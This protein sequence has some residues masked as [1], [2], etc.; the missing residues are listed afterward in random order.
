MNIFEFLNLFQIYLL[1]N[2]TFSKSVIF[3]TG[4]KYI[5]L[6]ILFKG[7]KQKENMSKKEKRKRSNTLP[8]PAHHA[9]ASGVVP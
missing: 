3:K 6:G 7:K 1:K 5:N 8:W 2:K 4:G 9:A